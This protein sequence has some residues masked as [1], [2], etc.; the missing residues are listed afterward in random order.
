MRAVVGEA[1]NLAQ[2]LLEPIDGGEDGA[3]F[4]RVAGLLALQQ[5]RFQDL[6]GV[7]DVAAGG[8]AAAHRLAA[9]LAAAAVGRDLE[10]LEPALA[11]SAIGWP[12]AFATWVGHV[13]QL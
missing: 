10:E 12:A 5:G 2:R 4:H 8:F 1:I 6:D 7:A 11:E 3:P 13:V 9:V